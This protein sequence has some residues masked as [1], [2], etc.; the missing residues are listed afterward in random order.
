MRAVVTGAAGF[1]GSHLVEAL[2]RGG[3]DVLAVDARCF[4]R[5]G[6]PSG[7][8]RGVE[9]VAADL[10]SADLRALL[11]GA[12]VV[13]HLA[14]RPGV[15]G[16]WGVD[17]S[18]Y[19]HDNV[20][21]TQRLLEAARMTPGLERVVVASSSSVYGD[22]AGRPSREADR[23]RP[24][25]PYGVTKLSAEHLCRV[26]G[27]AW[28]V[29][30]VLLRLFTVYGPGQRPDMA[31]HRLCEAACGGERFARFGSG[32]ARRDLTYVEDAVTAFLAAAAADLAPA[33]P[34]N[35]AGGS[36]TSLQELI[37]LVGSLAGQVVPIEDRPAEPGDV[38]M[39]AGDVSRAAELLG[40]RPS[41]PL[42][43]GL[44]VQLAWHRSRAAATISG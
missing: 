21:A 27:D 38:E 22:T 29:P 15:R 44:A 23:T 12:D 7:T 20:I 30:S 11:D 4:A 39:T 9:A 34:I 32:R 3:D 5:D 18:R 43:E 17:F 31:V 40:W 24:Q 25:S 36:V 42:V 8:Q 13:F 35:V 26:Y 28:G 1:I 2:L 33:T 10:V 41:T 37:G 16:S 6:V 19:A 14:G